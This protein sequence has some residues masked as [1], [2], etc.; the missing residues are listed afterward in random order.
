M[1]NQRIAHSRRAQQRMS[2]SNK[3]FPRVLLTV[4]SQCQAIEAI[5][6]NI[7]MKRRGIGKTQLGPRQA[8]Q[9]FVFP[10]I[11]AR[12]QLKKPPWL[13]KLKATGK[14]SPWLWF[15]CWRT[16]FPSC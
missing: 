8:G 1:V 13:I 7:L 2:Q 11:N 4:N 6:D 14:P 12:L 10:V 5:I 15:Q 16:D 9:L 3:G